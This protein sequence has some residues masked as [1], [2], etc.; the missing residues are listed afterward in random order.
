[1]NHWYRRMKARGN[2]KNDLFVGLV[3]S[4]LYC[5][6]VPKADSTCEHFIVIS[7]LVSYFCCTP[8]EVFPTDSDVGVNSDTPPS[9]FQ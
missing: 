9:E 8:L 4:N 2:L 7:L 3:Y 5:S 6:K 1:M